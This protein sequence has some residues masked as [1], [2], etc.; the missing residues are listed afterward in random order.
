MER[1]GME[2]LQVDSEVSR[3][4]GMNS[5]AICKKE[6]KR[7]NINGSLILVRMNVHCM[8]KENCVVCIISL[9]VSLLYQPQLSFLL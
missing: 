5:K 7:P 2:N 6:G 9:L 3:E 8:N 1:E 4:V